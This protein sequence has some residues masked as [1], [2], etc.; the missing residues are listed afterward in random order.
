[1]TASLSSLPIHFTFD[2]ALPYTVT[3]TFRLFSYRLVDEQ[4][5]QGVFIARDGS[6]VSLIGPRSIFPKKRQEI[7]VP[8]IGN[9]LEF[10][11]LGFHTVDGLEQA[12]AKVIEEMYT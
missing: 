5:M 1:M 8:F 7:D 12:P 4:T 3:K 11:S 10:L 6:A 9:E 2:K